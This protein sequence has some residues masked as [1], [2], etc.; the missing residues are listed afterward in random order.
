LFQRTV[1]TALTDTAA[2]HEV[3]SLFAK[4]NNYTHSGNFSNSH[5]ITVVW[6]MLTSA[7]DKNCTYLISNDKLA[8]LQ[9]EDICKDLESADVANKIK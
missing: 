2:V 5:Q 4:F 3:F 6:R 7:I 1:C 9:Q 8:S